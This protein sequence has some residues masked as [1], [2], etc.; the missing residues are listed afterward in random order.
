MSLTAFVGASPALAIGF[1]CIS[2]NSAADCAAGS[3]QLSFDV[4]D[5]GG[6]VVLFTFNNAGPA[7]SS[8]AQVYFDDGALQAVESIVNSAGVSFSAGANPAD[9]PSGSNVSPPFVA[10]FAFGAD[11]PAPTNGVNPGETLGIRFTLQPGET[12]ADVL[13][14]L[15][16]GDLRVGIHVQSFANGFS[17]AFVNTPEPGGLTLFGVAAA[18]TGL[19]SWRRRGLPQST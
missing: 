10:T 3:A 5:A 16:N 2:N 1:T 11:N 13:T 4:A 7:A 14:A 12:F 17:E 19:G 8:I 18:L 15:E 9:L 6:G